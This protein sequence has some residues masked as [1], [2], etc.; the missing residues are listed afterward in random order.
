MPTHTVDSSSE[1]PGWFGWP[2]PRQPG[3]GFKASGREEMS[4]S[5][6][7]AGAGVLVPGRKGP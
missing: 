7:T 5:P 6:R 1:D 3:V 2:F 4:P